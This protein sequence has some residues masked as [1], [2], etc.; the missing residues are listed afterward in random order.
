MCPSYDFKN[1]QICRT[2]LWIGGVHKMESENLTE[3][4]FSKYTFLSRAT[5]PTL[6]KP[7][8]TKLSLGE[9]NSFN[10]PRCVGEKDLN[11]CANFN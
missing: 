4:H 1:M 9:G 6:T 5:K 8:L 7:N 3:S 10:C 11:H 2:L